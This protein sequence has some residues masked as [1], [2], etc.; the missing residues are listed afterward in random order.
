M[1]AYAEMKKRHQEEVNAFPLM[2]AFNN[3]QFE[4]G[5]V[6]LGLDPNDTDKIVSIGAGG[7]CRK[8]DA[9]RLVKMF[10]SHRREIET[11]IRD[12][13]TGDGFI[14][15]MFSYE[16]RNHEYGYTRSYGA[17]LNAIGL[18]MSAV[19]KD[20]ALRHGLEKAAREIEREDDAE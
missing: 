19:Q 15:E 2:F 16:L 6:K 7:Y 5:M 13:V 11:A 17:T 4:E 8:E 18:K 14:Y 10:G 9:T 20:E 12:D 1:N 3:T